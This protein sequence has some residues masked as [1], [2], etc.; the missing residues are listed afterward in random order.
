MVDETACYHSP[1]L[2][3]HCFGE[4]FGA[5]AP[6]HTWQMTFEHANLGSDTGFASLSPSSQLFR[7][8][9]GQTVKQP[10]KPKKGKGKGNGPGNGGTTTSCVFNICFGGTGNGN[11]N[12]GNGGANGGPAH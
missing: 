3:A 5:D 12:G 9:N 1:G 2:G 11:G 4:M 8:G 6:G 10:A 7:M